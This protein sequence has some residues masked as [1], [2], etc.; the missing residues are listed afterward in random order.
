MSLIALPNVLADDHEP[1][2]IGGEYWEITGIKTADGGWLK[3][4]KWLASEWKKNMEF[5]KSEGWITRYEVFGNLHPRHDEPDL[6]LAVVFKNM[7]TVEEDEQRRKKYM[8]WVKKSMETMEQESGDRAEYR[9]VMS[10]VLLQEL[11]FRNK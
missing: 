9:T 3:Y 7:S 1:P 8:E 10:T 6:Y 5:A 11:K 4:E 2:F